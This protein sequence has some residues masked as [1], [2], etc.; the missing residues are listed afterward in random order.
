MSYTK[1]SA[2]ITTLLKTI[3]NR[4]AKFGILSMILVAFSFIY[5]DSA[6]G[7]AIVQKEFFTGGPV[8]TPLG[9]GTITNS[10]YVQS[11]SGNWQ[12]TVQATLNDPD[13]NPNRA[14]RWDENTVGTF[15][16]EP[17]EEKIQLVVNPSGHINLSC[18]SD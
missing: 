17:G 5:I 2:K 15:C 16:W 8:F 1:P 10:N 4:F 14:M 9:V 7:Q 13:N 18:K 6:N 3:T 12:I 11:P